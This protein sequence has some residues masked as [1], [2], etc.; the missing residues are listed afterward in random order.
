MTSKKTSKQHSQL[1]K[2]LNKQVY[3]AVTGYRLRKQTR[4]HGNEWSTTVNGVLY[5][6]RAEML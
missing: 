1:G 2:I 4:S 6:V 5:A 3:A